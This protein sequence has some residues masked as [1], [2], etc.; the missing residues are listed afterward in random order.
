MIIAAK[1]LM[2]PL[3]A[4]G[5]R[6]RF[7]ILLQNSIGRPSRAGGGLEL[8]EGESREAAMAISDA[9]AAIVRFV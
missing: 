9:Q 3:L 7:C 4:G 8:I 2:G 5:R 1:E 6:G